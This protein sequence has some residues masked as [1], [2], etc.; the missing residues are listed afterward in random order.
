MPIVH[1]SRGRR[2]TGT[3]ALA[4]AHALTFNAALSSALQAFDRNRH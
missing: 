4:L 2:T 3:L 1:P